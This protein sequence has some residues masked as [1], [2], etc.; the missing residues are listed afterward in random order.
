[1]DFRY[2]E[3]GEGIAFVFQHGLGGGV[4]QPF[5]LFRPPKGCR[6]VAFDCRAHG[7]TQPLGPQDKIGITSFAQDLAAFLNHL[8]IEQAIVG[9]ISMGAAVALSFVLQFP[10]RVLGLVQSRPAWLAGPN[11]ENAAI[12]SYVARLLRQHGPARGKQQFLQSAIYNNVLSESP[13]AA[14]SLCGQFDSPFAVERA[15]RLDQI[16]CDSAIKSITQLGDLLVPTIVMA[17]RQDPIHRFEMG[18]ALAEAIQGAEFHEITPKSVSRQSHAADVQ[19]NLTSFL[20]Y[21]FL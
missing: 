4:E 7:E 15:V 2:R 12:F 10:Q 1:L 13:D 17:N 20:Q 8:K 16:P 5:G 19:R 21:H 3:A 11:G 18:T 9:G 14:A 6:L